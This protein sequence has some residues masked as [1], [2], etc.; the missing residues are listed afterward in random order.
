MFEFIRRHKLRAGALLVSG[1]VVS[2]LLLTPA[3]AHVGKGVKHLWKQHIRP[4]ADNRYPP[5]ITRLQYQ[6]FDSDGTVDG[7][8]ELLR[9]VGNFNKAK[10]STRVLLTWNAHASTD[11]SFC[12][13]Q[14]R[15]DGRKDTGSTSNNYEGDSAGS[16]VLWGADSPVAVTARFPNLSSGSHS[17]EIWVRGG[18][19]SCSL[20]RGNFGQQVLVEETPTA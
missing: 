1:L 17:V 2:S 10:A 12:E 19:T 7:S 11:G 16:A 3:G 20:N 9:T 14:L 4:L 13:F 8:Y 15:I 5:R 6:G 18:A